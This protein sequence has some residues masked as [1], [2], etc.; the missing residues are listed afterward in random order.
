MRFYLIARSRQ[1]D[2]KYRKRF[3]TLH[4][5]SFLLSQPF[6]FRIFN[7]I[8]EEPQTI[9]SLA[10]GRDELLYRNGNLCIQHEPVACPRDST[11]DR[12][13]SFAKRQAHQWN[14]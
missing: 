6:P 11:I 8:P 2:R 1:E 10:F 7:A 13:D 12:D 5:Y 9:F 3:G 4:F 14:Y